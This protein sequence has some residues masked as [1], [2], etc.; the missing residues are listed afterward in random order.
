MASLKSYA[1][2][3]LVA[4]AVFAM[5][6]GPTL[7]DHVVK[8]RVGDPEMKAAVEK[9][10]GTL[11][12]FWAK[13]N[14]P[15]ANETKFALK[16]AMTENGQTEVFWCGRVS[17]SVKSA[18]CRVDNKLEVLTKIRDGDT[19]P[20]DAAQIRDWMYMRDGKIVGAESLKVLMPS[21]SKEE[22]EQLRAMLADG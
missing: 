12:A 16:I 4:I 3:P 21:M 20:V 14:A 11:P 5:T 8:V 15:A 7:Q 2:V 1:I 6:R 10:R 22:Q 18:T 17:G 9:A 13:V 19:I